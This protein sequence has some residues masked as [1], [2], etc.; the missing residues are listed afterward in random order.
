MSNFVLG[1]TIRFMTNQ[2]NRPYSKPLASL[3]FLRKEIRVQ[4]NIG[5]GKTKGYDVMESQT[6]YSHCPPTFKSYLAKCSACDELQNQHDRALVQYQRINGK[7]AKDIQ[8]ARYE[9]RKK[10]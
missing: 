2:I 6:T 3:Y 8:R 5:G 9:T 1:S 10:D 7:C 4:R